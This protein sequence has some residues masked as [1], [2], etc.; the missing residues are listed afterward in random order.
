MAKSPSAPIALAKLDLE[1]KTLEVRLR[2]KG[3]AALDVADYQRAYQAAHGQAVEAEPLI[4]SIVQA[5]IEADRGFQAWRRAN[6]AA[7]AP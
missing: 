1:E 4:L 5:H 6:P 7:P 3:K 2:F